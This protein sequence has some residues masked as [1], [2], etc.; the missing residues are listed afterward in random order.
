MRRILTTFLIAFLASNGG[1][2]VVAPP[3]Q[4]QGRH[5]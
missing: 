4:L 3:A 5:Q 1:W 2:V